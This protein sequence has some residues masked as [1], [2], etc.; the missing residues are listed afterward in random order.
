VTLPR[1][2]ARTYWLDVLIVVLVLEGMTELVVDRNSSNSPSLWFAL[3]ALAILVLPLFARRRFPFGGLAAYWV[4][5]AIIGFIDWR[6][7]PNAPSLFVVGLTVSFLLGNL[8]D[9]LRAGAGLLTVLAGAATI[10]YLI[11]NRTA[12]ELVFV[13]L[14]FAVAWVAGFAL[15]ERAEQAEAAEVRA[16][17]AERERDAAA[18]VAVA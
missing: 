11:P 8:R 15:R 6:P 16:S 3:P 12:S 7:V 10:V 14:E 2:I 1:R 13:P 4:I 5:A 18:R 17:L 9:D